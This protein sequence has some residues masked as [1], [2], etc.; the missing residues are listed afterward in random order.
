MQIQPPKPTPVKRSSVVHQ[1]SKVVAYMKSLERRSPRKSPLAKYHKLRKKSPCKFQL[2]SPKSTLDV[3]IPQS[4]SG[5]VSTCI[6]ISQLE[7]ILTPADTSVISTVAVRNKSQ[8][9]IHLSSDG[10]SLKM[11]M[12]KEA[13]DT[14]STAA[15]LPGVSS[16]GDSIKVQE[17]NYMVH[18]CTTRIYA[19]GEHTMDCLP[20]PKV[21][22][23]IS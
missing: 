12:C 5:A 19:K 17:C 4:N 14:S 6:V 9:V 8:E 1:S 7:S 20:I 10:L 22:I 15:K 23:S 16:K 11:S 21:Y 3:S 2:S 13:G 18:A